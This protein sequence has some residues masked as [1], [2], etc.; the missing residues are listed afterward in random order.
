[1]RDFKGENTIHIA[2]VDSGVRC[3][4]NWA[5]LKVEVTIEVKAV[6]HT[7]TPKYI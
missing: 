7:D 4:R 2:Q 1:M 5:W 6:Q 3:K